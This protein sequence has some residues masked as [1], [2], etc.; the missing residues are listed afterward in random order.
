MIVVRT[1][2]EQLTSR[3]VDTRP[4]QCAGAMSHTG[5]LANATV[6]AEGFIEVVV[7]RMRRGSGGHW[8]VGLCL[9]LRRLHERAQQCGL[10]Q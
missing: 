3:G 5:G 6:L 2:M 7:L 10:A 1:F 9:L 4:V 8:R